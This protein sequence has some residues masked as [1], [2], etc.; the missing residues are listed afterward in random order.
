MNKLHQYLVPASLAALA[1]ALIGGLW[2]VWQTIEESRSLER[3]NRELQASLEASRIR[4]ANFCEYPADVLCRTDERS[5]LV[6][7]AMPGEL[8]G[9]PDT[10]NRPAP[11]PAAEIMRERNA[12]PSLAI[13]NVEKTAKA[14]AQIPAQALPAEKSPAIP[15]PADEKPEPVEKAA[16]PA[17]SAT[18][19]PAAEEI[20][21]P[22]KALSPASTADSRKESEGPSKPEAAAE[23]PSASEERNYRHEISGKLSPVPPVRNK[24]DAAA[25][26]AAANQAEIMEKK[27]ASEKKALP[28]PQKAT[29]APKKTWSRV[30]IDGDIY[31]F[32]LTGSGP[33]LP[34]KGVLRSSPWR[35]ELR[36][37]GN[38]E[39]RKHPAVEHRLVSR[40][41]TKRAKGDTI[42]TFH[43]K[44]KPYRCSLHRPDSRS[45]SVRIR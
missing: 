45:V 5:G 30:E 12:S 25:P 35:Y 2:L 14:Q 41:S 21:E 15:A 40:M 44:S 26:A 29:D 24:E 37:S 43:L 23:T 11:V 3:H 20:A 17:Q 16:S 33:S 34:A 13:E 31:A 28:R 36:L 19:P 32:A 10:E 6:A 4:V 38:W 18:L 27:E 42:V 39:I 1:C 9:M 8:A 7:G 22:S